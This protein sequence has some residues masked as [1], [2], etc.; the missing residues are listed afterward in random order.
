MSYVSTVIIVDIKYN[1]LIFF[2]MF[3]LYTNN[4]FIYTHSGYSGKILAN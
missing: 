2:Y 4:I 3:I 1:N